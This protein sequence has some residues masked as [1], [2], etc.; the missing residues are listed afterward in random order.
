MVPDEFR[1]VMGR[2]ASGVTVITTIN[3]GELVGTTASAVSSLSLEPPMLLIC[4]NKASRTG[5]AISAAG[6]F[7]V[8]ILGEDHSDLAMRFASKRADKFGG[9]ATVEGLDGVPLLADAIATLECTV[10]QTQTGGTHFVFFAEVRRAAGHAGPPLAYFSGQ[11]GRLELA[12]D[13]AAARAIRERVLH[14]RIPVGEPLALDTL[15]AELQVPRGSV[16][17]ALAK[18]AAEGWVDHD[19]DGDFVVPPVTFESLIAS[20]RARVALFVGAAACALQAAGDDEVGELRRR[21]GALRLSADPGV[22]ADAWF[23]S[24][25]AMLEHL[26]GMTGTGSVLLDAFA[27]ADVPAQIHHV[28]FGGGVPNDV[29]LGLIHR[30]Y[31][32]IVDACA[33]ADYEALQVAVARLTGHYDQLYRASPAGDDFAHG[34]ARP[35]SLTGE[36]AGR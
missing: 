34:P 8:N 29:E 15:A 27:R 9:V 20:A 12:E 6:R 10:S 2:F 18:L 16:Y 32:A 33:S 17:H 28:L 21:L 4:I 19:A 1:D 25:G 14:R 5:R 13:A 22:Q 31:G 30:G 11:F 24:R 36:E 3:D 23:S 35:R 26:M 7:A